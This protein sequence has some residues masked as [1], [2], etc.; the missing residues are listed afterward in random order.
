M[1]ETA[2]ETHYVPYETMAGA[3]LRVEFETVE[4]PRRETGETR[5]RWRELASLVVALAGLAGWVLC[6]VH[7]GWWAAGLAL[8]TVVTLVGVVGIVHR[9]EA[10]PDEAD[11]GR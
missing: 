9:D 1:D 7:L 10:P 8:S 11:R 3:P 6:L 4:T 5:A 2:D